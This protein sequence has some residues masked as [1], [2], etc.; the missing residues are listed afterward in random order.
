MAPVKLPR[1]TGA[2]LQERA[3]ATRIAVNGAEGVGIA[4]LAMLP[5]TGRQFLTEF[6][7]A[8]QGGVAWPT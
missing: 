2:V 5:V 8:I 1:V 4:D 7:H 6:F 3:R